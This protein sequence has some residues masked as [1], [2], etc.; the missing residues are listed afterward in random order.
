[1]TSDSTHFSRSWSGMAAL[2]AMLA[3]LPV[4]AADQVLASASASVTN[5]RI[6]VIDLTP[7]DGIA[8]SVTFGPGVLIE[9]R[10][11][12]GADT[13]DM[14][15]TP[16]DLNAL[17]STAWTNTLSTGTYTIS[18]SELSLMAAV[19]MSDLHAAVPSVNSLGSQF[20]GALKGLQLNTV[21]V[22]DGNGALSTPFITGAHTAVIISGDAAV[23]SHSVS[24]ASSELASLFDPTVSDISQLQSYT[25]ASGAVQMSLF[26]QDRPYPEGNFLEL[27]SYSEQGVDLYA[28]S[29]VLTNSSFSFSLENASS[30]EKVDVFRL[31]MWVDPLSVATAPDLPT[32]PAIPEPSTCTL[33]GLGLVG[34]GLAR[35]RAGRQA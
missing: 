4:Q 28:G 22:R 8:A 11:H 6:Q 14:P 16:I 21:E 29:G 9:S 13:V 31:A 25:Q 30:E 1:M 27:Y 15:E 19:K 23:T 34:I 24:V 12:T 3:S 5:L 32:T 7:D 20:S 10:F 35:R 17:P 18:S 33:M 26:S 2:M